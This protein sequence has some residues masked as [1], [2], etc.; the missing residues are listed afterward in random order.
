MRSKY[1]IFLLCFLGLCPL[2]V[3]EEAG[4][5]CQ[6]V[7]KKYEKY[8]ILSGNDMEFK[9]KNPR[10]ACNSIFTY[11]A[12][13]IP[14][15]KWMITSW[16]TDDELGLNAQRD[17]FIASSMKSEASYIGSIPVDAAAISADR[18]RSVAQSGGSIYETVYLLGE[19]SIKIESPGRELI[20]SDTACIYK[21]QN[22]DLCQPLTGTLDN[23]LCVYT[24]DERKILTDLSNCSEL[25]H[26]K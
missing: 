4:L 5:A 2:A 9:I 25:T 20:F 24:Y 11:E 15:K 3:S 1:I 8:V 16:P 13:A 17:L 10:R 23:P 19:A 7:V 6:E 12:I 18:Y 21:E 22:D 26:G 14:K